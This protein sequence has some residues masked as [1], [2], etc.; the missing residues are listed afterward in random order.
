M[1]YVSGRTVQHLLT[2]LGT[3]TVGDAL[4]ILLRAARG[5]HYAHE[6][7]LV[8]RDIKPD[9]LLITKA[10]EVKV[11]DLGMVKSLDEDMALTQ[12]GHAVGTPWYM[13]LEQAKN[14]KDADARCDIYALGCV[15]YAM[16]TGHPPFSGRTIVEV[17]QAKEI[18]TFPPARQFNRAVPELLDLI[19][20][21]MTQKQP[22]YRYADCAELIRDVERLGLA[23]ETL[24]FLAPRGT[25][26][27]ATAATPQGEDENTSAE[28]TTPLP[29]QAPAPGADLWYVRHRMGEGQVVTRK[30]TTEQVLEMLEGEDF[31]PKAR[32]SRHPKEGF[33]ALATYRE[34][35]S[36]ALGKVAKSSADRQASHYRKLYKEIEEQDRRQQ[37]ELER[38]REEEALKTVGYWLSVTWPYAAAGLGGI[39]LLYI[40]IRLVSA[41]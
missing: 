7:G 41:L 12:T 40:L 35:E 6:Q 23:N 18:G 2:R 33:R 27:P 15:L 1:E 14:S 11:A 19:L 3:F 31:D 39:L 5:L 25:T 16:L 9:N 36:A 24:S 28:E 30:L 8:H 26:P 21:K 38:S 17:I 34:F 32:A 29:G 13:P 22:R 4:Y 20:V 10:G 37:E